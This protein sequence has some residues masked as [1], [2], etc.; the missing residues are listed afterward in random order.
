MVGVPAPTAKVAGSILTWVS[1]PTFYIV[2]QLRFEQGLSLELRCREQPEFGVSG[3]Q[4][5]G[6]A[7]SGRERPTYDQ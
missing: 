3:W 6:A 1:E 7:V 5:A 2:L 4:P